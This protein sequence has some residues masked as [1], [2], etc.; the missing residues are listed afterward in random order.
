MKNICRQLGLIVLIILHTSVCHAGSEYNLHQFSNKDGL[1][2]SSILSICQDSDGFLWIGSCDGL[3]TFDGSK[4]Q[5][6]IP[7]DSKNKISGNLINNIVEAEN[8]ILWIKTNYG[9]DRLNTRTQEIRH[10]EN[11]KEINKITKSPENDIYIIK[12]NGELFCFPKN[13]K[14]F[15]KVMTINTNSRSIR[16]MA[17]DRYSILW[18]VYTNGDYKSFHI[19]KKKIA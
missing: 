7:V 6:Y 1:S 10:F 12:D 16:Q 4:L 11:F 8:N 18:I 14:Y 3:N 2:N 5:T 19:T 13:G 15:Q 17:I 9:L